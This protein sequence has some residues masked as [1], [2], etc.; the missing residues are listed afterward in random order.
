MKRLLSMFAG[1][2]AG[3]SRL[4]P[5]LIRQQFEK[6]MLRDFEEMTADAGR[7]G[8]LALLA[9]GARELRDFPFSLI[10]AYLQEE[11]M[12]GPFRRGPVQGAFQGAFSLSLA[13]I[14]MWISIHL[15]NTLMQGRGWL[16]LLRIA[17]SMG[18][19]VSFGPTAQL[20]LALITYALGALLGGLVLAVCLRE[21]RQMKQ[22]VLAGCLGW[23]A[24][25]L[26]IRVTGS[27][28]KWDEGVGRHPLL[29]YGWFVLAGVGFG[30]VF[31][32]ILR[33]RRKTPGRCWQ[34]LSGTMPLKNWQRG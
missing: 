3:L 27:L 7:R 13:L 8:V 14:T 12:P 18:W 10:C 25:L 5:A 23:V 11:R 19:Y 17:E 22:Y 33:E 29:E 30:M 24:P 6:D 15:A 31:S 9:M 1:L 26:I 16:L 2:S 21:R 34:A 32:L 4:Y 28:M 20:M